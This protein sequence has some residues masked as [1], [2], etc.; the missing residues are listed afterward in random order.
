MKKVPSQR[1]YSWQQEKKF[2]LKN[3]PGFFYTYGEWQNAV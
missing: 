1:R 2:S 3:G